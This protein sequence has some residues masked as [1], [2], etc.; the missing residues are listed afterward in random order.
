MVGASKLNSKLKSSLKNKP[1][2]VSTKSKIK[3]TKIVKTI[4][5]PKTINKLRTAILFSG[6]KDSGL[7]LAYALEHTIVKC[8]IIIQS[9][10]SESYMFHT[11][12]IIW[13]KKQAQATG[14][15]FIVYETAGEKELEL[16]DLKKAILKAKKEYQIQAVVTGAIESVYQASR[17]Q[18]ITNDLGLECFNPLWQKDQIQVLEELLKRK[19]EIKIIGT[20]GYGLDKLIGKTIDRQFI[21]DVKILQEKLKINPAGEGGEY[22]SFILNAP[23]Y[24]KPLQI[25]KSKTYRDDSGGVILKIEE[26]EYIKETEVDKSLPIEEL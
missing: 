19:F 8:L 24:K 17:V 16:E 22:E 2:L 7:A 5:K 14:I 9:K 4:T 10:N 3:N 21:E 12:N 6:G 13:A 11:P 23:Y 18:T 20:F 1:R 25:I 26:L 15:P